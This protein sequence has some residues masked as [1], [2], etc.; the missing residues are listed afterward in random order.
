MNKSSYNKNADWHTRRNSWDYHITEEI[1]LFYF[2]YVFKKYSK[3]IYKE[4]SLDLLTS[5]LK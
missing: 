3:T 2:Q 4:N 5:M 1:Q